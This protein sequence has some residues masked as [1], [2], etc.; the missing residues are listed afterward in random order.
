MDLYCRL[1]SVACTGYFFS[2]CDTKYWYRITVFMVG[3]LLQYWV[4]SPHLVLMRGHRFQ[5]HGKRGVRE[6]G[7]KGV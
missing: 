3:L 6:G 4:Q 2:T 7:K 1:I 5:S